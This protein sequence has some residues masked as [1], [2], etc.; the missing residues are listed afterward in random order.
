MDDMTVMKRNEKYFIITLIYM[1]TGKEVVVHEDGSLLIMKR[2]VELLVKFKLLIPADLPKIIRFW[3][4]YGCVFCI[5][6]CEES[7][8]KGLHC[9]VE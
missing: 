2:F 5:G 9:V 4:C 8:G 6:R 7:V 1:F 3:L